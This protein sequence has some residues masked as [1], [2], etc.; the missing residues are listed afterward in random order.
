MS[1]PTS[2]LNSVNLH[3]SSVLEEIV[4]EIEIKSDF[5]ICHSHYKPLTIPE[6]TQE[7]F[8]K[9]PLSIKRKYISSQLRGFLYGIYYNGSLRETLDPQKDEEDIP[10]NLENNTVLGIDVKFYDQLH[11]S[12]KGS[13][14]FDAGWKILQEESQ[15]TFLVKKVGL[16]LYIERDKHLSS[17][18]K[19]PEIGDLVKIKLP[20]NRIQNGFY[21]AVGNEGFSSREKT[22]IEDTIVRIYFNITPKGAIFIMNELTEELNKKE[23]PFSFKVLYNPKDYKRHDSGV[24]YFDKQNYLKVKEILKDIYQNNEQNFKSGIPLFTLELAQGLGLAEEPNHRFSE[25]ESFGLNR[26]QIIAN[27]LLK[28]RYEGNDSPQE[29]MSAI[30]EQFAKLGISLQRTYL[31]PESEDIYQY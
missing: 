14:Y 29:R 11:K 31:N 9:M 23:I 16:K 6:E 17:K 27:G 8:A 24:L 26:C 7:N 12:N 10:Q 20:K 5:S 3:L 21:V 28:A 4:H 13:G 1:N 25:Q 30:K 22:G 15:N 18:E 2:Q 19:S